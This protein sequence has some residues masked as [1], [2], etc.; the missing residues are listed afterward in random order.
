MGYRDAPRFR[1]A[2]RPRQGV[3]GSILGK[4]LEVEQGTIW[5]LLA[6]VEKIDKGYGE[7]AIGTHRDFGERQG[8]GKEFAAPFSLKAKL[9]K[10]HT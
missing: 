5:R 3:C 10:R 9:A 6:V 8:P 7:W 2:P 4:R 1:R